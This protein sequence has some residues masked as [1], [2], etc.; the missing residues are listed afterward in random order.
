MGKTAANARYF[1][2]GTNVIRT[3][4]SL[5]KIETE[6]GGEAAREALLR[7]IE[8]RSS[9][10]DADWTV[11]FDGG[12]TGAADVERRGDLTIRY[13][14]DRSADEIV[15]EDARNALAV[16]AETIVVSSDQALHLRGA[17]AVLAQDF[18]E[19][20]LRKKAPSPA[21]ADAGAGARLLAYLAER[22]VVDE[23]TAR[24]AA[25][26]AA[27]SG[28]LDYFLPRTRRSG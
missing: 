13:A 1:I 6:R 21:R 23:K 12:R 9:N 5:A 7:L 26:G 8:R 19:D 20:L 24:D 11:V 2:D 18:Y 28:Q 17:H 4:L 27:L 14:W 25:L 15:L 16:G 22:G 3:N 10:S